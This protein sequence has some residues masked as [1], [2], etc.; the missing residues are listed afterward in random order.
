M[1]AKN[2]TFLLSDES[3]NSYGL[4]IK[5]D[6]INLKRFIKN[7]VM[8]YGHEIDR[9]LIGIWKNIKVIENKLFADAEFYDDEFSKTI[10]RKVE[11]GFLKGCSISINVIETQGNTITKSELLE[12]SICDIPSN[13][14]ALKLFY[15]NQ[16]ASDFKGLCKLQLQHQNETFKNKLCN[17]L[18]VEQGTDE[19]IILQKIVNK[20]DKTRVDFKRAIDLGLILEDEKEAFESLINS[21]KT[22]FESLLNKRFENE[23]KRI[24]QYMDN[25]FRM[26]KTNNIYEIA[27]L[28]EVGY[29][30]GFDMAKKILDIIPDRISLSKILNESK[31]ETSKKDLNWY[32]KNAPE[33]LERNPQLYE[34]LI[35]F[36]K[37]NGKRI[38]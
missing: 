26:G 30:M 24:C 15:N 29:N 16:L 14:N 10:Q 27:L 11:N 28:K 31:L 38:E 22:L 21:N 13:E 7:P 19:N 18:G 3:V 2:N 36:E 17:I 33:E 23:R 9:G 4:I 25:A 34:D 20:I 5:T 1:G 8:F 35:K 6:G 32:R 37:Q 12:V